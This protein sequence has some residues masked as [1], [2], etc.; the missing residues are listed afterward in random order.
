MSNALEPKP[1]RF[2]LTDEQ[3]LSWLQLY[4]SQNVGPVTFRD[5]ISHFGA[6]DAAIEAVPE[7]AA[8]GGAARK[9]KSVTEKMPNANFT[10][11]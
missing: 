2:K 7:L 9:I 10:R 6:A 4:R 3:K 5:L 8:N 11:Y 1:R